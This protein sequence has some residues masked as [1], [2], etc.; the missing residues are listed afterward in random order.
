MLFDIH[1]ILRVLCSAF[2]GVHIHLMQLEI[3]KAFLLHVGRAMYPFPS[4]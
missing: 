4:P 3:D 2:L 1:D